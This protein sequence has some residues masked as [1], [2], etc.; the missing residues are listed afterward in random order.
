MWFAPDGR[1]LTAGTTFGVAQYAIVEERQPPALRAERR[2]LVAGIDYWWSPDRS[3]L[4]VVP[5]QRAADVYEWPGWKKRF[6]VRHA[7][8]LEYLSFS[9]D[10][11]WLAGGAWKL[12]RGGVGVLRPVPGTS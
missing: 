9:P 12:G 8:R 1:S 2:W 11:R 6:T 4:A 5:E 3:L 7:G 10:N